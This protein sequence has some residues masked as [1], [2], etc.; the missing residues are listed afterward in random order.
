MLPNQ[1]E[2][3]RLYQFENTALLLQM[4]EQG[5]DDFFFARVKAKKLLHIETGIHRD[6]PQQS[7]SF[8]SIDFSPGPHGYHLQW[9]NIG[10]FKTH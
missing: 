8:I 9:R 6:D 10:V 1:T 5:L 7:R 3:N 2:S 4:G